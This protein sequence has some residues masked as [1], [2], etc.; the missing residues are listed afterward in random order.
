MI[1]LLPYLADSIASPAFVS[2]ALTTA[3][4]YV[5]FIGHVYWKGAPASKTISSAGGKISL[6]F[7]AVTFANGG[8]NLR[9]GIQDVSALLGPPGRGDGNHDVSADLVGGTDTITANAARQTAMETGSKSIAHGQ[10]IAIRSELTTVAGGDSVAVSY[11][12]TNITPNYPF[13]TVNSSS[14]TSPGAIPIALLEADD[15]TIGWL[16]GTRLI[17]SITTR[18]FDSG[19]AGADEYSSILQSPDQWKIA[20]ICFHGRFAVP[21]GECKAIIYSSPLGTPVVEK[22]VTIDT[23]K[24]STNA[25]NGRVDVLFPSLYTMPANTKIALALMPL[26]VSGDAVVMEFG[27]GS[28]INGRKVPFEHDG[29]NFQWSKGTRLDGTGAFTEDGDSIMMIGPILAGIA[30]PPSTVTLIQVVD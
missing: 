19:T 27:L 7:G 2:T 17:D 9:I 13:V 21:D 28:A 30:Q 15:G 25:A 20:G 6:R 12:D 8:T 11:Y 10:L 26:D 14:L 22:E 16:I 23:N 18:T 5:D 3:G 1:A 24:V 4:W 29:F